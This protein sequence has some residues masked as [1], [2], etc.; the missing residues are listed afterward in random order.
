MRM[1]FV[2]RLA[3][4]R[5]GRDRG[6][7]LGGRRRVGTCTEPCLYGGCHPGGRQV[8]LP[9]LPDNFLETECKGERVGDGVVL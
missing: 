1:E 4:S 5:R 9:R 7:P 2:F 6:D 8:S 3:R